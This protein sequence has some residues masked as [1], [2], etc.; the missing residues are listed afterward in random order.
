MS[1]W[2][3]PAASAAQSDFLSSLY[4]P[5]GHGGGSGGGDERTVEDLYLKS[6]WSAS[7]TW[8]MECSG[9]KRSLLSEI[10]LLFILHAQVQFLFLHSG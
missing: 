7:S 4:F 6:G 3:G 8:S 2:L 10:Q 5:R 9:T 1:V